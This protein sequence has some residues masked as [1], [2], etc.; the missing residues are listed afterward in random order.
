VYPKGESKTKLK[1]E[2][3]PGASHV[4]LQI[5]GLKIEGQANEKP[6]ACGGPPLKT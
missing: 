1:I 5:D 6:F 3:K 4:N 2:P